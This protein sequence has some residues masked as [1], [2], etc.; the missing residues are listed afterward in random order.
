MP[1]RLTRI[2]A[3]TSH[4]ITT[5][6]LKQQISR[7]SFDGSYPR[8]YFYHLRKAAGTSINHMFLALSGESNRLEKVI[9]QRASGS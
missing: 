7:F 2:P 8:V 5:W 1:R 3:A 6:R 4:K 9:V